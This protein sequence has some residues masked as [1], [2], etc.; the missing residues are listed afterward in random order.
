M[1]EIS[2]RLRANCLDGSRA[3]RT[4]LF[5]YMYELQPDIERYIALTPMPELVVDRDLPP[6][7]ARSLP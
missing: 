1:N 3:E 7:S 6:P 4:R 2:G 5:E